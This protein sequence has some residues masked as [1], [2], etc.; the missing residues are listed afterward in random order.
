[1]PS[2]AVVRIHENSLLDVV[3]CAELV[4]VVEDVGRTRQMI[5]EQFEAVGSGMGWEFEEVQV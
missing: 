3:A 1:M 5:Q 2:I 4:V